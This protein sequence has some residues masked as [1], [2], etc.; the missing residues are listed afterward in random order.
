MATADISKSWGEVTAV[1]SKL[2]FTRTSYNEQR[3]PSRQSVSPHSAPAT[4]KQ[5]ARPK[6]VWEEYDEAEA[7]IW[8]RIK[9]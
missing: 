9:T 8:L 4:A 1:P 3:P 2:P 6:L 5:P 7:E